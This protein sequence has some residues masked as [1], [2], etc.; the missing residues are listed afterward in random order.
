[1]SSSM[2]RSSA[3]LATGFVLLANVSGVA[4]ARRC[5]YDRYGRYRCTGGLARAARIGLGIGMAVLALL[6]FACLFM[7]LKIRRRRALKHSGGL[8]PP[9][10]AGPYHEKPLGHGAQ[11]YPGGTAEYPTHTGNGFAHGNGP[12]IPEPTYQSGGGY[13][14]PSGPPPSAQYAPPAGP[15]PAR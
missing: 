4:A 8:P 6:I 11:P 10:T 5:G 12:Q 9:A 13:A 7:L 15:P 1:M 3:L 2:T 14:P